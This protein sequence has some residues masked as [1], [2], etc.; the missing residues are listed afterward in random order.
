MISC[1]IS[2]KDLLNDCGC[3]AIRREDI[4]SY[5]GQE[6]LPRK[7]VGEFVVASHCAWADVSVKYM[8][9][10]FRKSYS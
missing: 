8:H 2:W 6:R 7:V 3:Q 4:G 1:R 9:L 10:R 5:S